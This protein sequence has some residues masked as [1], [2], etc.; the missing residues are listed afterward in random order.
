MSSYFHCLFYNFHFILSSLFLLC[1]SAEAINPDLRLKVAMEQYR[2]KYRILYEAYGANNFEIFIMDSD[3]SNRKNLTDTPDVHEFYPKASPDGKKICFMA[4]QGKADRRIRC[5]YLMNPDGSGRKKIVERGRWPCWSPDSKKIAYVKDYLPSFSIKDYAT[6]GLYFYDV[7]AGL[8]EKHPNSKKIEHIYN[9]S[10]HKSG[11]W[12]AAVVHGGLSFDHA[13]I[14]LEL[15]SNK[16]YKLLGGNRCRPEFHPAGNKIV[17]CDLDW[18]IGI[19]NIRIF[20]K[21]L[22][23]VNYRQ[24]V[25]AEDH[26]G[27]NVYHPDFSPDGKFV[28]F[29]RGPVGPDNPIDIVSPGCSLYHPATIGVKADKWDICVVSSLGGQWIRLTTDGKSNKE[30]DW[31]KVV[32]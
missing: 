25:E 27:I 5:L 4:Y 23:V 19:A 24:I 29:S 15:E 26:E 7:A 3:G 9:L 12:L 13:V 30:P 14:T 16:F 10:W 31:I 22:N 2:G 32:D 6:R 11:K 8:I 28:V 18:A 21:R 1:G 20:N 17:W